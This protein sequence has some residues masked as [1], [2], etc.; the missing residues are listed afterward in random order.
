MPRLKTLRF[1]RKIGGIVS[2]PQ[3]CEQGLEHHFSFNAE[4]DCV[5]MMEVFLSAARHGNSPARNYAAK[6][7]EFRQLQ[8][9]MPSKDRPDS[10]PLYSAAV[11][12]AQR[13]IKRE[14]L[15]LT[16]D[17]KKAAISAKDELYY[18][19][20]AHNGILRDTSDVLKAYYELWFADDEKVEK[21][22]TKARAG[23]CIDITDSILLSPQHKHLFD[24]EFLRGKIEQKAARKMNDDYRPPCF[25][26]SEDNVLLFRPRTP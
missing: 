18:L 9:R 17:W 22:Q 13:L 19:E 10:F 16:T 26:F 2:V 6:L 15:K 21:M 25:S 7:I 23:G 24:G 5:R 20:G 11:R 8:G 14:S 1:E 4:Q 12:G 3:S